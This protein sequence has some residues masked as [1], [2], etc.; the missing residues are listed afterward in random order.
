[1]EEKQM[2]KPYLKSMDIY[3]FCSFKN[4]T[5]IDFSPRINVILGVQDAGK[6]NL[7]YAIKWCLN[8]ESYLGTW[9]NINFKGWRDKNINHVE[10]QLTFGFEENDSADTILK[11][12][13]EFVDGS[14]IKNECF[15]NEMEADR[16]IGVTMEGDS[17]KVMELKR[18]S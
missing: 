7:L 13:T 3:G 4:H 12:R 15:I 8:D 1:M 6:T 9:G 10:V 11:R 17:S 2:N 14:Q 16:M 5:H 18:Q